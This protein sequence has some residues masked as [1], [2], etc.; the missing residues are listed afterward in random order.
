MCKLCQIDFIKSLLIPFAVI[1]LVFSSATH[2]EEVAPACQTTAHRQFDF[3]IGDWEVTDGDGKLVGYNLI[4]PILNGC[5]LSE[6]WTSVKGNP[7]VSYNFYDAAEKKWHQTWIDGSGG[8][9]YLD[10]RG[11]EDGIQRKNHVWQQNKMQLHGSRPGKNG[12][13]VLHQI[14]WSLLPDGRVKQHW[15]SS[16]DQGATWQ[17]LFVGFYQR[18]SSK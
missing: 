17:D 14:S 18:R 9:L 7:G 11:Q 15:Q 12:Q 6:N 2:A 8:A 16:P 13:S 5:A 3:W 4:K 10:S 1:V